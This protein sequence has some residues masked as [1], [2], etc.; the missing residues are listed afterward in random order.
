[1][2]VSL[3]AGDILLEKS[4]A[5]LLTIDG[6][7]KTPEGLPAWGSIGSAFR[8]RWQN[9]LEEVENQLDLPIAHGNSQIITVSNSINHPSFNFIGALSALDHLGPAGHYADHLQQSFLLAMGDLAFYRVKS[10][11][12]TLPSG[13]W[14]VSIETAA[15]IAERVRR[16][17]SKWETTWT[18]SEHNSSRFKQILPFAKQFDWSIEDQ[19]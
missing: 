12:S 18:I 1:M 5:L 14:R 4:E 7:I 2:K 17:F 19:N 8:R 13:G 16:H 3:K 11:L 6:T 15:H 9:Y 10:I